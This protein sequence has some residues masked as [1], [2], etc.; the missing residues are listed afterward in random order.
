MTQTQMTDEQVLDNFDIIGTKKYT[1]T[2]SDSELERLYN[3][4]ISGH[5][6]SL[7]IENDA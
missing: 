2:S 5:K 1:R 3:L 6:T 4:L 7:E